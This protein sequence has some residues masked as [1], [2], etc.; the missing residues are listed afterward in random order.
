[1]N[2][3]NYTIDCREAISCGISPEFI[4]E[5]AEDFFDANY[6]QQWDTSTNVYLVVSDR[7]INAI[8]YAARGLKVIDWLD[9]YGDQRNRLQQIL[10]IQKF[11][12]ELL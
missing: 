2:N 9:I 10:E 12:E 3:D 6:W 1:M 5:R 11:N 8:N 4:I 7:R